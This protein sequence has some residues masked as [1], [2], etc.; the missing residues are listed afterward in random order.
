MPSPTLES[1]NQ[2][3]VARQQPAK[4]V[5]SPISGSLDRY[6]AEHGA[7]PENHRGVILL[8]TVLLAL[9]LFFVWYLVGK[10][11]DQVSSGERPGI[12]ELIFGGAD[13]AEKLSD[14]DPDGDGLAA[15]QEKDAGTDI[16]KADTDAD[17]LTDRE[18]INVYKTNPLSEDSDKDTVSDR[19]E[20]LNRTDPL[21]PDPRAVWPPV[22]PELGVN[23]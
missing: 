7:E 2:V 19:K 8:V 15:K 3:F 21:N 5:P 9:I 20:I 13:P 12:I 10:N 6:L 23:R 14:N 1:K 11:P 18:E 17:G 22:P 4:P 16:A